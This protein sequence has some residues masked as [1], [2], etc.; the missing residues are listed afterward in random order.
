MKDKIRFSSSR[1]LQEIIQAH[2][3]GKSIGIYSICSAN[4]NVL[5]AAMH[6]RKAKD[7]FLLIESTCNQVN[8]E[9]GYTGMTPWQF[10]V[11]IQELAEE[12]D[13][14]TERIM[15]GG[16]HLGPN[17]WKHEQASIAMGKAEKLVHDY[18]AAGYVK[19]HL[20]TSMSCGNEGPLPA[21]TIAERSAQLCMQAE[22]TAHANQFAQL[23]VYVIGTEVPMPGGMTAEQSEG[24]HIT[25]MTFARQTLQ[26]YRDVFIHHGLQEVLQRIIAL[27]VSPGVEFND[28]MIFP[29]NRLK[30]E[31]LSRFIEDIPGMVYEAHSTDYQT[32][33]SLRQ[34][35]EDHFAILKVGPALTYAFREAV[36]NLAAIEKELPYL[37]QQ[38]QSHIVET[39]MHTMQ[40]DRS[41]W[42]QYYSGPDEEIHFALKYSFSD[43]VRYYWGYPAVHA[44]YQ[45][46]I[47]NLSTRPIPLTLV[48]QYFPHLYPLVRDELIAP[49]PSV[50]LIACIN[51]VLAPY[52]NACDSIC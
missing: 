42:E 26:T 47:T 28:K 27:V 38:S 1:P 7:G 49:D 18:V 3:K 14:P 50:L 25:K 41:H 4:R 13:F 33:H 12:L 17:P 24:I 31:S 22:K 6:S 11:Y 45:K 35:V 39:L 21:D 5:Q 52:Q 37:D 16:D 10:T 2:K 40:D 51:Q 36:F 46:L 43:R 30:T 20:D 32:P 23:P 48:S 9:G 19:I 34:M 29:Y 44:S 8:Q 15:L